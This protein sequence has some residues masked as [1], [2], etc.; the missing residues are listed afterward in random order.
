MKKYIPMFVVCGYF[1]ALMVENAYTQYANSI[2]PAPAHL[3]FANDP[4]PEE[5]THHD[6]QLFAD[7]E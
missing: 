7:E 5:Q 1:A 6:S 4:L 3:L 2:E